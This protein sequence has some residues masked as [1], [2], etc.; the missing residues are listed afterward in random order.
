MPEQAR[1]NPQ[2]AEQ[3]PQRASGRELQEDQGAHEA[4]I[5][6]LPGYPHQERQPR[7][8]QEQEERDLGAAGQG[9]GSFDQASPQDR[10][11]GQR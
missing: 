2:V 11:E 4:S 8:G 10:Q 1:D 6:G 3:D 7:Q 9:Q 5:E